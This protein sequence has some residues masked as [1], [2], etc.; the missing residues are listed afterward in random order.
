MKVYLVYVS[1]GPIAVYSTSDSAVSQARA[2]AERTLQDR[3]EKGDIEA[4]ATF[5]LE[6]VYVRV[7]DL[8]TE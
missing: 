5:R 4:I 6:P 2:Y 7:M 8:L 3:V 1:R